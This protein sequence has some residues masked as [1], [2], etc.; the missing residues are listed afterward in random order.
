MLPRIEP[1]PQT[2]LVGQKIFT[3]FAQ[4]GTYELW[5][6]FAPRKKEIQNKINGHLYAVEIYPDTTFFQ[7]FDPTRIFE[8]WAAVPVADFDELPNGMEA[9]T[10]P[11]GIYAVF[12]YKGKPSDAMDTFR[13]IYGEWLT[14]SQYEMDDRPYFALMDEQYK[15]EHPESEET[16]WIPIRTT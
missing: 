3:S 10:I 13:Y 9:L 8:K 15:G 4:D 7:Q 2:K 14:N 1:F 11:E 5:R 6:N 12:T 16:F